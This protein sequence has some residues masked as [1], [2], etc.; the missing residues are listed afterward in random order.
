VITM[1]VMLVKLL[2]TIIMRIIHR[3]ARVKLDSVVRREKYY[4]NI[5]ENH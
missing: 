3:F 4:C 2:D 5:S 1:H